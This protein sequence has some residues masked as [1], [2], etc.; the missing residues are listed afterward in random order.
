MRRDDYTNLFVKG[1]FTLK[2]S[3]MKQIEGNIVDIDRKQI[4]PGTVVIENGRI[5]SIF[6]NSGKQ[7]STYIAPGFIDAHVHIESSMLTPVEFS[8]VVIKKGTIAVVNDPHEIANVLGM[9]GI[10]FM[11]ENSQYSQIKIFFTIPSC[12]PSTPFDCSGGKIDAKDI[13]YL[14][15][16][17]LFIGLSEMMNIPGVIHKDPEVCAKLKIAQ[18]HNFIIDGHAPLLSGDDL[19]KYIEA[20]IS[21]D[22]E[23]SELKE[24]LE[25]IHFGMKVLI[26]EGSAAKNYEALKSIIASH[27]DDVMFCTDDSHPGD[28]L[29]LGHIDKIVK[30]A[31][32]DGF[33]LFTAL[34]IAA[35]NPVR[36]YHLDVGTLHVGDRADFVVFENLK[37]FKVSSA[38]INGEERYNAS[39]ENAFLSN[40]PI[41]LDLKKL[42]KFHC[43]EISVSDLRKPQRDHITCIKV[44][45]HELVTEKI[46]FPLSESVDNLQ[47]DLDR[48][49]LKIVY[50][51]RY[52]D[53]SPQIA[54]IHGMG[55]KEGAFAGSISH[56]SH[57]IIAVG[58][59]D[60]D[61]TTAINC[62]I[63]EKGGLIAVSGDHLQTLPLPIAGI[64]TDRTAEEVAVIWEQ[65]IEI[66]HKRGCFLDS[67]FMTLSF[68]SL[69]VIPELK[70]GEEGLFEFSKFSFISD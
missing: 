69:I 50:L 38:Y 24:A 4:F 39:R 12:V 53:K 29:C 7:Y 25:K 68:M 10:N 65:L 45:D 17:G 40:E 26:R 3:F 37:D 41:Y 51:N 21:T 59:N 23:S 33:D 57:N 18:Q 6:E 63:R 32:R 36:Y 56:D 31:I 67:P 8:K 15:K 47:S 14:A 2:K 70:I 46:I 44:T 16:S 11:V 62:L 60:S 61:I 34:K 27:P 48:D 9:E 30:K 1:H 42:N 35:I 28:L 55:L 64:M 5:V 22:H 43:K 54:Y 58:T 66:L 20:G 19:K 49:I 52:E 13:E